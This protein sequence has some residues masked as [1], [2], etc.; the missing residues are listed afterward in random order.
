MGD[1][2]SIKNNSY[3]ANFFYLVSFILY[4]INT[5]LNHSMFSSLEIYPL[6]KI[7]LFSGVVLFLAI[8]LVLVDS[9]SLKELL[10]YLFVFSLMCLISL[11]TGDRQLITLIALIL[12]AKNVNFRYIIVT[13]FITIILLLIFTYLSTLLDIIPNL[14]YSRIR[15]GEIKIRN[16][17][18]TI[19]PTVFAAYLQSIV[20]AYAY[21]MNERKAFNHLILILLSCISIFLALELADARL[22]GYSIMLFL[23]FYYISIIFFRR[24]YRNKFMSKVISLSYLVGFLVI[25]YL[26]YNFNTENTLSLEINNVLSGRLQLGYNA[27]Q[28]YHIPLLG[29]T[30]EFIGFGGSTKEISEELYNYV[31]SSYLQFMLRY[32]VLFTILSIASYIILTYK[33]LKLNDYKFISIIAILTINSMI[34]DRLLDVS[35][36][37]YWL[38]ILSFYHTAYIKKDS[39][40]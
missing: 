39:Y 38:L 6:I 2:G 11:N 3:Y 8:K 9:F 13:F 19:Y 18:G 36:N 32:G 7:V 34:E 1:L 28:E 16:S 31:D 21:L 24:I 14:Q 12:G 30:I 29:Q 35:I 17:F 5:F 33:R 23:V 10:S 15:D 37:V 25:F 26:S 40:S 4:L 22:S 27:F 20:I